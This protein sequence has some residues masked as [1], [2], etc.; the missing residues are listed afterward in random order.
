MRSRSAWARCSC[1]WQPRPVTSRVTRRSIAQVSSGL[2]QHQRAGMTSTCCC[3][4]S[5]QVPSCAHS[6]RSPPTR[7]LIIRLRTGSGPPSRARRGGSREG[8]RNRCRSRSS[9]TAHAAQAAQTGAVG[10]GGAGRPPRRPAAAVG[11]GRHRAARRRPAGVG[12]GPLA[13]GRRGRPRHRPCAAGGVWARLAWQHAAGAATRRAGGSARSTVLHDYPTADA[14]AGHLASVMGDGA[15]AGG[16]AADG[17]A[18]DGAA[19]DG[20]AADGGGGGASCDS[21]EARE[22][23]EPTR[24]RRGRTLAPWRDGRC[25]AA[26]SRSEAAA[27]ETEAAGAARP[28]NLRLY[29]LLASPR[30]ERTS[31]AASARARRRSSINCRK[32]SGARKWR[33]TTRMA[34]TWLCSRAILPVARA[35]RCSV[36]GSDATGACKRDAPGSA[37]TAGWPGG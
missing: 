35:R 27:G 37:V 28:T 10:E 13:D 23:W 11:T 26:S 29:H 19:A 12:S 20:A 4:R 32:P 30:S 24:R 1:R 7:R 31:F 36:V 2:R 17:A 33:W 15:A 6:W 5:L 34:R 22:R 21:G 3:G 16:A 9:T 25:R 18:A 14:L 8:G